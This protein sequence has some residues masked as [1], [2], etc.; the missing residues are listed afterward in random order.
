MSVQKLIS[1]ADKFF[2]KGKTPEGLAKLKAALAQ[3]PLNQLV[4]TKLANVLL[5]ENQTAE[6]AKVYG[7]LA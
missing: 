4:A 6:A 1:E 5:Q 7:G 3:E 2:E